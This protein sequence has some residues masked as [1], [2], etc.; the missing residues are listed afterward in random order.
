[1][2]ISARSLIIPVRNGAKTLPYC[3]KALQ[4]QLNPA[5]EILV[6]NDH[7]TDNSSELA[8]Q[9]GVRVLHCPP[10]RRGA[11]AARN[12]G[13]EAATNELL[14]FVDADVIPA[15]GSLQ[16][17]VAPIGA[18]GLQALAYTPYCWAW[19]RWRGRVL[20]RC[21]LILPRRASMWCHLTAFRI[22]LMSAPDCSFFGE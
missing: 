22:D 7:S 21:Y 16:R 11:A 14:V 17:L 8:A 10:E 20:Q 9:S 15:P 1:M 19:V 5:D 13:A 4:P 12:V 3:L 6:V 18:T 2:T